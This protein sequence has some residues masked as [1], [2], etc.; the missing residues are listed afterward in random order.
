MK[1][2]TDIFMDNVPKKPCKHFKNRS[3][4]VRSTCGDAPYLNNTLYCLH[5]QMRIN[6]YKCINCKYYESTGNVDPKKHNS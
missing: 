3:T 4:V 6:K 2:Y 1:K 5:Y